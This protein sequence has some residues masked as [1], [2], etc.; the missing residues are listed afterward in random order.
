MAEEQED[1]FWQI[2][3]EED[4]RDKVTECHLAHSHLDEELGRGGTFVGLN[5]PFAVENSAGSYGNHSHD[6][7]TESSSSSILP[8]S[9]TRT[10]QLS[11]RQLDGDG[12]LSGIGGEIWEASILLA[13]VDHL[14][15]TE[16]LDWYDFSP[17]SKRPDI[18]SL[19]SNGLSSTTVLFGSALVYSPDLVC[20]A[21]TIDFLFQHMPSNSIAYVLQIKDRIGFDSFVE[22]LDQI[23]LYYSLN[24]VPSYIY[25]L[26]ERGD[27]YS[28]SSSSS[29]TKNSNFHL[30]TKREDFVL[31]AVAKEKGNIHIHVHI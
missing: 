13:R 22:R 29:I 31:C 17:G 20:V 18:S 23:G 1:I 26:I 3:L 16:R 28:S 19:I 14:V 2:Q 21:D 25:N 6:C 12:V 11:L 4:R 27:N 8:A 30:T 10:V 15:T 24:E 7:D 5:I 9:K